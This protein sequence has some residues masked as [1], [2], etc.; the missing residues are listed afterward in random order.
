M[1]ITITDLATP[2][3]T[4]Q[5]AAALAIFFFQT[6]NAAMA[7]N[8]LIVRGEYLL[9][10]GGCISCHTADED[11]AVPLAGGRAI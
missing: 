5:V 8:S 11:D 3:V 9:H 7:Q 2:I 10:A 6:V 1:T 4:R